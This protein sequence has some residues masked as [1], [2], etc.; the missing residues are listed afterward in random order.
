MKIR[1]DLI[2]DNDINKPE[3]SSEPEIVTNKC[4]PMESR[5]LSRR[6]RPTYLT[7]LIKINLKQT[8]FCYNT[9]KCFQP[10]KWVNHIIRRTLH[11]YDIY[12]LIFKIIHILSMCLYI[13]N[14]MK[15]ISL[16][17][18]KSRLFIVYSVK[19]VHLMEFIFG[20]S[21]LKIVCPL[22][23]NEIISWNIYYPLM[24]ICILVCLVSD[25]IILCIISV[26]YFSIIGP[27][28]HIHVQPNIIVPIT[29]H[30]NTLISLFNE[31][32]NINCIH[33]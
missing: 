22:V 30:P 12:I 25:L 5:S 18:N 8:S 3:L 19:I 31:D 4:S 14:L 11:P 9:A 26:H 28:P 2:S 10:V 23:L 1:G 33:T 15:S 17:Y 7:K 16:M 29:F 24:F 32:I 20:F 21:C 6:G 27:R 13:M